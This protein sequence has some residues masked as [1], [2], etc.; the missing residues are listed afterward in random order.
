MIQLEAKNNE[1]Q[2]KRRNEQNIVKIG[3]DIDSKHFPLHA[4][5]VVGTTQQTTL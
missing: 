2:V 4:N 1:A 3:N 5:E